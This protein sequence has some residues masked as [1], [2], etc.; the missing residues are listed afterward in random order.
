MKNNQCELIINW[1]A[2]L[3]QPVESS[4]ANISFG[5]HLNATQEVL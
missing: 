2:S 5:A 4:A 3:N 1:L